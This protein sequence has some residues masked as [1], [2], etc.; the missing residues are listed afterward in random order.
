MLTPSVSWEYGVRNALME[1]GTV[2]TDGNRLVSV[3]HDV[4]PPLT[5]LVPLGSR[6]RD[7][8]PYGWDLIQ[9]D[10]KASTDISE[11]RVPAQVLGIIFRRPWTYALPV[12]RFVSDCTISYPCATAL[13]ERDWKLDLHVFSTRCRT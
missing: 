4:D 10:G 1:F 2:T 7:S 6:V 3:R 5:L 9:V 13:L 11:G 12:V 8:V